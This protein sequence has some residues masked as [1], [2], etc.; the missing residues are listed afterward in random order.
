M[1]VPV[2]DFNLY[3]I[4]DRNST[5]GRDLSRV[6]EEALRGG[7]TALQLRE[8]DLPGRD[9]YAIALELRTLTARYGARLFIN[10]RID[11]ALAVGADGVHLGSAGMPLHRARRIV[12]ADR[13]IGFSC[14]DREGALAA[15]DQGADFITFGPV[16]FT[17][18]KAAYGD[19]VG[20]Q[21]LAEVCGLLRI[22]VFAIGGINGGNM[23]LPI[24]AGAQGI[25]LISAIIAAA[26]P[27]EAARDL[28]FRLS[29]R[30]DRHHA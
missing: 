21:R 6:V 16:F 20:L 27:R 11:I 14:H 15:Q 5:R 24:G 19:P 28:L 13:L 26:D 12:G 10:D 3:L 7:V 17:P 9:L 23:E 2:V 18:S 30:K 22:P 29:E 1:T 8:K 4:T 25:A